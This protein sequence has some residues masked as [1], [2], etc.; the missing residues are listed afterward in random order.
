[1]VSYSYSNSYS[2]IFLI[3]RFRLHNDISGYKKYRYMKY[4][5]KIKQKKLVRVNRGWTWEKALTDF[6]QSQDL[7]GFHETEGRCFR[8]LDVVLQRKKANDQWLSRQFL[9]VI[10]KQDLFEWAHGHMLF[11]VF[12]QDEKR[13]IKRSEQMW[14]GLNAFCASWHGCSKHQQILQEGCHPLWYLLSMNQLRN[15]C[16][17]SSILQLV[18]CLVQIGVQN[19]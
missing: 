18:P 10:A 6:K 7:L 13:P 12:L 4:E 1:M 5:V 11:K 2:C 17:R 14:Q 19:L 3:G 15:R 9:L 16:S 8:C